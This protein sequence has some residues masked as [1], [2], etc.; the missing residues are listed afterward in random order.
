M[1]CDTDDKRAK[2]RREV[3][4]HVRALLISAPR[5]LCL[6]EIQNDYFQM[7][8]KPLPFRELG[9]ETALDLFKDMPTVV[10]PSWT[11]GELVLR[12]K[13]LSD[14]QA[15]RAIHFRAH[16]DGFL[17]N[18]WDFF[19]VIYWILSIVR[20]TASLTGIWQI[21]LVIIVLV[22]CIMRLVTVLCTALR[23]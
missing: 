21:V 3:E 12:G 6:N 15:L 19:E 2:R 7:I 13:L 14:N 11:E 9:F 18:N 10:R 4:G 1:A 17:V 22:L 16:S 5:G 8:G 23:C 20:K